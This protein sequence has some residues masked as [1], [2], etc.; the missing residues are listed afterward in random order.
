MDRLSALIA[1]HAVGDGVLG[2]MQVGLRNLGDFRIANGYA[3]GELLAAA[4]A[5]MIADA[6]RPADEVHVLDDSEVVVLLPRLRDR[7]HAMLAG[8]RVLRIFDA[9]VVAG[10]RTFPVSVAIGLSVQPTDGQDAETLLRRA[11]IARRQ[12]AHG[13]ERCVAYAEGTDLPQVPYDLLRDAIGANRLEAHLQPIMDVA[14]RKWVGFE[15]LARWRDPERGQ[16]SP[17]DFIAVAEETGLVAELTRW[18]LNT[19]LRHAAL[20]RRVDPE[21]GVSINLSPR[22]FGQ[23]DMLP[24]VLS[25][26]DVWGL[27]PGALTLEVTET[28]L[29]EDFGSSVSL[30]SR[31]RA[32]GIGISIDDF[33]TGQSSL[34]YIKDI[35]A[36]ELKIDRAFM[37]AFRHDRR[38]EQLVRSIIDLGHHLDM[39]LVAEGVEDPD[40]LDL[41]DRLGCD[42]AQGNLIQAPRPAE[43]L[44]ATLTRAA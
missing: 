15:S 14:R 42:R 37:G 6:L 20:A 10:S 24:Q 21:L 1:A 17:V 5:R 16:V 34:A 23:R 30:L 25:A 8:A 18:S 39:E 4:S 11:G 22:V 13:I 2:V 9:P 28:A 31:L 19:S 12:A 40:T 27:P 26:L 33:G 36:T 32:E 7:N 41:L 35:P 3:M 38:A 43:A 44:I 29:M